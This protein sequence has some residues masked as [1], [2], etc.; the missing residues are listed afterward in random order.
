MNRLCT[1]CTQQV[2]STELMLFGSLLH[3]EGHNKIVPYLDNDFEVFIDVSGTTEYYKVLFQTIIDLNT[4]NI[5][6]EFEMNAINATYD[7]LW[8]VPDGAG[9]R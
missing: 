8:G 9:L 2:C 5:T 1:P 6:Q 7:V 3:T 4:L